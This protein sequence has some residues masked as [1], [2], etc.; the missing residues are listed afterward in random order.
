M[1][2]HLSKC[3]K[4]YLITLAEEQAK[5]CVCEECQELPRRSPEDNIRVDSW[6]KLMLSTYREER[7]EGGRT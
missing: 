5:R 4:D 2:V 7:C 3:E 1:V 6:M